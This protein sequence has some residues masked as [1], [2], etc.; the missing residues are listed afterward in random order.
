MYRAQR[1]PAAIQNRRFD[2][3][4]IDALIDLKVGCGLCGQI[5]VRFDLQLVIHLRI[6]AVIPQRWSARWGYVR[7]LGVHPNVIQNPPDLPALDG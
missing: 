4:P 7:G 6:T 5:P 2:R 1:H 3:S